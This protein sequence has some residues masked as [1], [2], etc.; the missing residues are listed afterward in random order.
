[1]TKLQDRRPV[2]RDEKGRLVK[3]AALNPGGQ[4]AWVKELRDLLQDDAKAGRA[5][6]RRV[7]DGER[8][9]KFVAEDGSEV[10]VAPRLEDRIKAAEIA[11]RYTMPVPKQTLE[12]E[13]GETTESAFK[14]LTVEALLALAKAETK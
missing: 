9:A 4:P 3:G 2:G 7:I 11:L 1:M 10:E 5:L 8:V 14:A 12:I 13:A 6:L